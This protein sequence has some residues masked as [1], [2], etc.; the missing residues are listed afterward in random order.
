VVARAKHRESASGE[1]HRFL[2]EGARLLPALLFDVPA[3]VQR[4][5]RLQRGVPRQASRFGL[6]AVP[7][8]QTLELVEGLQRGGAGGVR[9]GGQVETRR[10]ATRH[11]RVQRRVERARAARE[12]RGSQRVLRCGARLRVQQ[13]AHGALERWVFFSSLLLRGVRARGADIRG[14]RDGGRAHC[15]FGSVLL[16]A[17]RSLLLGE[18]APRRALERARDHARFGYRET[19]ETTRTL[20]GKRIDVR[21]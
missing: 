17:R 15:L 19:L 13:R 4:R 9:A 18:R 8:E 21:C 11:R 20:L 3:G 16:G 1:R 6:A 14:R 7:R 2:V 12:E 5:R 10:S